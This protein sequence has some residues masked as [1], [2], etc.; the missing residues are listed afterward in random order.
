VEDGNVGMSPQTIETSDQ[1]VPLMKFELID[2]SLNKELEAKWRKCRRK[3][4]SRRIR[5]RV[6]VSSVVRAAD[7]SALIRG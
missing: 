4:T 5:R 6:D 3:N 2:Q 7:P 1:F